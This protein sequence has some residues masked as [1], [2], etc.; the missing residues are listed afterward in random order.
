MKYL[1]FEFSI[2]FIL[3][4]LVTYGS[5]Q[6]SLE[7]FATKI[8]VGSVEEKREALF[9]IRNINT[10]SASR[11]AI[12]ALR[13]ADAIVRA[14][15]V[16]S[17]LALSG[18]DAASVILPLISDKEEFVR[19]EAA[20]AIGKTKSSLAVQPLIA[21]LR[22][23]T[24]DEVRGAV[25]FALGL[26]G[27]TRAEEVLLRELE[28]NKNLFAARSAARSLGQVRS[29]KSIPVL[30]AILRDAKKP[31]DIKRES[32]LALGLIG[33]K[34]ATQILEENLGSKDYLLAQICAESLKNINRAGV[35]L[36]VE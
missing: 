33:D 35:E 21:R 15:A 16:S 36:R 13:D 27:D 34:S 26:L 8:R 6:S 1:H 3:F 2:L 18:D 24:N 9:Q 25:V 17:V 5:A 12:P 20:Y 28:K 14:T 23:E 4:A 22:K 11:I 30:I 29:K 31:D 32:A 19:K 10:E 7:D